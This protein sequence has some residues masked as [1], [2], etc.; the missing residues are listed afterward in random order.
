MDIYI[1]L[2]IAT[3]I[4]LCVSII[5][6]LAVSIFAYTQG[7]FDGGGDYNLA[8]IFIATFYAIGWVIPSLLMW[9]IY[10]TWFK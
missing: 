1:S 5:L 10:A 6:F 9:A 4:M 3:I 8:P 7:M 2:S